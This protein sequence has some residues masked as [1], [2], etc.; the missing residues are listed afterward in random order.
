MF[1]GKALRM[2]NDEVSGGCERHIAT[3]VALDLLSIT[4]E[5]VID[6]NT[7]VD[8]VLSIIWFIYSRATKLKANQSAQQRKKLRVHVACMYDVSILVKTT[9]FLNRLV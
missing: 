9:C 1:Y 4:Q 3:D 5:S 2:S 6:S 7:E 8:I